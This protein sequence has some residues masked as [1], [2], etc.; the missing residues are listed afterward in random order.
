MQ[1]KLTKITFFLLL[2]ADG[3]NINA[4]VNLPYLARVNLPYLA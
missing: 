2:M 4:R 1:E 3:M